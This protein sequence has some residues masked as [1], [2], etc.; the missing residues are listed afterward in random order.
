MTLV[1]LD[2]CFNIKILDVSLAAYDVVERY[3]Y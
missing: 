1:C 3:T 2:P